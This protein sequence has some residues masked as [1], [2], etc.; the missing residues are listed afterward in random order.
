MCVV[1]AGIVGLAHAH[2][3]RR[4]G[5]S[6]IVIE[7]HD[8][9]VGAS[10]RNFGH[11]AVGA[12]ADGE[13]LECGL[14][15]RERWLELGGRAGI[16]VREVGSLVVARAAD[17][18]ELLEGAAAN[19][20]RG[21]RMLTPAQAGDL[22]PIP[23]G[24]LAGAMHAQLDLRVDP[25]AAVAGL[26]RLLESE[27]RIEWGAAVHEIEPGAVHADRLTVRAPMIVVCPGPDF[28]ALAPELRLGLEELRLC[29][30]QM[31]RAAA[32]QGRRY[33]PALLTGLS[34]IRYPAFA[35][36]PGAAQLRERLED[37]SPE[38][39]EAGIHLIV[40]QLPDGDL[41]VGDTHDYAATPEPF[42]HERRYELLLAQARR[43]LGVETL[44]VRERWQGIYPS[45]LGRG[46]FLVTSPMPGVRVVEVI[47]GLGMTLSFGQAP[48]VLDE[49]EASVSA[50]A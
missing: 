4:R 50:A 24:E 31:L 5:L 35:R 41:I 39:L 22:A 28:G 17:E 12:L 46:N 33:A 26:A 38:L 19:P 8:R 37:E 23:T 9:A 48:L 21:A 14:R 30:L 49:L 13:A 43:L 47:S 18:L 36:Q 1:G 16:G 11:V 34:L 32:P 42:L 7:R 40:T 15:A 44:V 27:A 20:T 2:E 45:I 25:R 10:V 6:V 3:A 29:G